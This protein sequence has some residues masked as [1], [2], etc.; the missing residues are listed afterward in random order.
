M[1]YSYALSLPTMLIVI[2]HYLV[3]TMVVSMMIKETSAKNATNVEKAFL[4]MAAE[5]KNTIA[6][7]PVVKPGVGKASVDPAGTVCHVIST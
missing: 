1:L 6:N 2:S 7:Q 4:T 5:I 3:L